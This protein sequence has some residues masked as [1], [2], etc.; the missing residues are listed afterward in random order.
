MDMGTGWWSQMKNKPIFAQISFLFAVLILL[1]GLIISTMVPSILRGFFT[2]EIYRTI[3][4]SQELTTRINR[5][6]MMMGGGMAM[7][8]VQHVFLD[9]DGQVVGGRA[10]SEKVLS[11]FLKQ[12]IEQKESSKRYEMQIDNKKMLY[13]VSKKDIGGMPV[14]QISFMMDTYRSELVS[15]L[16]KKLYLML[17]IALAAGMLL[18]F[19]FANWMVRP[20][21]LMKEHVLNYASRKWDKPLNLNRGDEIGILADSIEKMR[22]QLKEQDESQQT[23]LQNVSHDL[24]TPVMV[25]RSY[26][27]ALK[28]KI[29]PAG[30]PEATGEIIEKEAAGLEKKVRDLIYLTKLDYLRRTNP[31]YTQFPLVELASEVEGR[32]RPVHSPILF[33]LDADDEILFRGNKEQMKVLFENL[34]ENAYKFAESRIT[35]SIKQDEKKVLISCHNDGRAIP[36]EKIKNL[37]KPFVKGENGNFG[38]GL[39]IIS[40]ITDMHKGTISVMNQR[41]GVS[42][43]FEFPI[44]Y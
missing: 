39:A 35:L 17:L 16:L 10:F 37:F 22:R 31:E 44:Q 25:I 20:I 13:V 27:E 21:N 23:L 1:I 8:S 30:T 29:Y 12:G 7:R 11:N 41:G 4:E 5:N 15:T 28:E 40:Q 24:K 33:T 18:S 19:L 36:E 6:G 2:D 43:Y 14:F 26:A 42:F 34:I 9:E 32:L 38:L 3:E